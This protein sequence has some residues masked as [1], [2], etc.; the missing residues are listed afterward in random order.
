M[1]DELNILLKQAYYAW[2][3]DPDPLIPLDAIKKFLKMEN[4]ELDDLDENGNNVLR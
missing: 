1:S 2:K 3:D 4:I